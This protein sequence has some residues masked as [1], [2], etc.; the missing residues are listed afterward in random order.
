[1][2]LKTLKIQNRYISM[3]Q[4]QRRRTFDHLFSTVAGIYNSTLLDMETTQKQTK[5]KQVKRGGLLIS[6]VT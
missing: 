6:D 2:D 5:H 1:M 4:P 3:Y